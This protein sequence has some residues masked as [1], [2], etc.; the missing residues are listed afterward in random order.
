MHSHSYCVYREE[1][2]DEASDDNASLRSASSMPLHPQ[3]HHHHHGKHPGQV[4]VRHS[5][6]NTPELAEYARPDYSNG[7]KG[8]NITQILTRDRVFQKV[9][10]KK[11]KEG[12]TKAAETL[13]KKIEDHLTNSAMEII[14]VMEGIEP[15]SSATFQARTSYTINNIQ[16]D[17]WFV[18][19]VGVGSNGQ[20][21]V[22]LNWFNH[23]I[24]VDPYVDEPEPVQS[25]L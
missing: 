9:D 10:S 17:R 11:N 4:R 24:P 15:A 16:F 23:T 6:V 5:F 19:C 18:P 25:V 20:A 14:V 3:V 13:R 12:V 1:S 2:E 8:V 7:H 22:N 21:E